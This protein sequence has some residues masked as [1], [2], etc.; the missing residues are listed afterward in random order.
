MHFFR[1]IYTVIL[2]KF[3]SRMLTKFLGKLVPRTEMTK[4]RKI[5]VMIGPNFVRT[6]HDSVLINAINDRKLVS[7]VSNGKAYMLDNFLRAGCGF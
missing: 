3:F 1:Y 5:T 6:N 2:F 7:H 4:M